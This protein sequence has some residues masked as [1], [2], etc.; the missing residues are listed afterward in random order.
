M[1]NDKLTDSAYRGSG[2]KSSLTVNMNDG[3]LGRKA[4]VTVSGK[5]AGKTF[6]NM[7]FFTIAEN[8]KIEPN[9]LEGIVEADYGATISFKNVKTIN[10]GSDDKAIANGPV[11]HA[12]SGTVKIDGADSLN[13]YGEYNAV[14]AQQSGNND[15]GL[16]DINAKDVNFMQAVQR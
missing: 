16:V 6:S 7:D 5:S 8:D 2:E 14:Q 15:A 9:K 1:D 3:T 4:I 11:I 10:L 12:F 13:I